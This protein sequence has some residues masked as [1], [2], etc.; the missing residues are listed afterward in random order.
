MRRLRPMFPMEQRSRIR[1]PSKN[2]QIVPAQRMKVVDKYRFTPGKRSNAD[3]LLSLQKFTAPQLLKTLEQV[4]RSLR[5]M[6]LTKYGPVDDRVHDLTIDTGDFIN[7][8]AA[9]PKAIKKF[10]PSLIYSAECALSDV[11]KLIFHKKKRRS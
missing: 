5:D 4:H 2:S 1:P 3:R 10:A 8:F 9:D 11:R 7:D 6:H